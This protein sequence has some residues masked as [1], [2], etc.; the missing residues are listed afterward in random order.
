MML[1]IKISGLTEMNPTHQINTHTAQ[2]AARLIN[3]LIRL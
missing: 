3:A 2:L 1:G